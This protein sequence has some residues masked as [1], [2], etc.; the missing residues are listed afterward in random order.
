MR[1]RACRVARSARVELV[2]LLL[3]HRRVREG[4]A[5]READDDRV[6]AGQLLV[7]GQHELLRVQH[8]GLVPSHTGQ[9]LVVLASAIRGR[10]R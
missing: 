10:D 7:V 8:L 4:D 9:G 3:R 5:A 1:R 6:A 2:V